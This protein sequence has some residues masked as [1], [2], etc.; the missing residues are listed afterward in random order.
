MARGPPNSRYLAA[1]STGAGGPGNRPIIA[2]RAVI[3]GTELAIETYCP[4]N[5]PA[6]L[7][8]VDTLKLGDTTK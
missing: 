7:R 5:L 6:Y 8:Q 3:T 2:D 1:I 4:D